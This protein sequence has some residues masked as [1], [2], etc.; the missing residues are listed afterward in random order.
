MGIIY[1]NIAILYK[2]CNDAKMQLLRP[3]HDTIIMIITYIIEHVTAVKC[4]PLN[5]L[6][7]HRH[8]PKLTEVSS[9]KIHCPKCAVCR[10]DDFTNF[11]WCVLQSCTVCR[12]PMVKHRS[13]MDCL[14]P[15]DWNFGL[16]AFP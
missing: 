11:I 13:Q 14:R 4:G 2:I 6:I 9:Q 16:V 1:L 15:M 10:Y 12:R 3:L 8:A 5:M 7:V